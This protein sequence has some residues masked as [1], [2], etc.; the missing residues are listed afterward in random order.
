MF[1]SPKPQSIPPPPPLPPNPPSFATAKE[2][3]ILGGA[4]AMAGGL[5]S[6]ILTSPMGVTTPGATSRKTLLG[7]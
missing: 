5:A 4:Q 2:P 6:T 7:A 3:T 1:G